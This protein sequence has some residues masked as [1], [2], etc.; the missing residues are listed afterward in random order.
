MDFNKFLTSYNKAGN[1]NYLCD[2]G[3]VNVKTWEVYGYTH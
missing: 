3:V 2:A 1:L